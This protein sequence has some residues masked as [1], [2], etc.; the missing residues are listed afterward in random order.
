MA[1]TTG[2]ILKGNQ[3]NIEGKYQLGLSQANH[4]SPENMNTMLKSPQVRIIENNAGYVVI[5]VTCSCGE[6]ITLRGEYN[7]SHKS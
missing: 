2:R 3:V 7:E 5:Q 1:Q 4:S 6:Q